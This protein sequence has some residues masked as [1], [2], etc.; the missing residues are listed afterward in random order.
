MIKNP[1]IKQKEIFLIVLF[2]QQWSNS[3]EAPTISTRGCGYQPRLYVYRSIRTQLYCTSGEFVINIVRASLYSA[4]KTRT[5]HVV[6][7]PITTLTTTV[8]KHFTTFISPE[9]RSDAIC[10]LQPLKI[11]WIEIKCFNILGEKNKY[12]DKSKSFSTGH[13][14]ILISLVFH[15]GVTKNA[16]WLLKLVMTRYLPLYKA[17]NILWQFFYGVTFV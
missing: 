16:S 11:I 13:R 3:F 8:K 15:F 17:G 9:V 10:L 5:H 2:L 14:K 12:I 6:H 7:Y 1:I 4:C